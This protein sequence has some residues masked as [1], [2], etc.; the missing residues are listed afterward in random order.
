MPLF[1]FGWLPILYFSRVTSIPEYFERRFGRSVRLGATIC[2][3]IYLIMY[4]G[5]NLYTMGT[6]LNILLGWGI[7]PAAILVAT[8]SA[9]YV[10]FGGQTSV[11]MTDLLQGIMLLAVGLLVLVLGICYLGGFE[12]FWHHLPRGHRLAFPN[13]NTDPSFSG[14]GIFWQD[15]MANSAMFYFL[16]QGIIMRFLAAKSV[17]EAQK[18]AMFVPLVLMPLAACVVASGGWVG[19]ALVHAGILPPDIQAKEAFFV[20][21]EFLSKPGIF[22]LIIAAL[23]AALMSTVDTLITAVSAIAVNDVYKPYIRPKAS[24]KQLLYIAR[25]CAI[26]VT[27]MGVLLVPVFHSFKSIYSAHGAFTATVTPPLVVVLLLSV[28]WRR[29]TKTAALATIIGG[30]AAIIFSLFVP[31]VIAPFAHGVPMGEAGEGFLSGMRQ[32]K[33]MRAF[34]GL[35]ISTV[36]AV[37]VTLF[38]KPESAERCRGLVWGTLSDALIWGKS[39]WGGPSLTTAVR[40]SADEIELL[41][42]SDLPVV[43]VSRGLAESADITVGQRLY[44]TD[45]RWWLGGLFSVHV[46]V[47]AILEKETTSFVEM[48]SDS[49]PKLVRPRRKDRLVS[50]EQMS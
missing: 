31:E 14:V 26:A 25:I 45:Q 22:G 50:L 28:F 9:I 46:V 11:I 48:G 47:G 18:V 35:S 19:K 6:S 15:S 17:R 23:T 40:L 20:A 10:T 2:I 3:L 13:F 4:V 1:I 42:D 7:W 37:V 36:I 12:T 21:S 34:Y 44:L 43:R 5:V 27:L 29:F 30:M 41:S 33:F 39:L 8:V 24:E 32:Y 38:T 16:N 49:Y